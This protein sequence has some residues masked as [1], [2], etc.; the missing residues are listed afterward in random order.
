MVLRGLEVRRGMVGKVDSSVKVYH[1][2]NS[3]VFAHTVVYGDTLN[4]TARRRQLSGTVGVELR[5]E[6]TRW[7][8]L[9][10]LWVT[11]FGWIILD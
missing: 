11:R 4:A 7:R 3:R 8:E 2:G 9:R 10:I 6:R 5:V 1:R